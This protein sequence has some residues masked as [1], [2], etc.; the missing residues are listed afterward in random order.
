MSPSLLQLQSVGVQDLYLTA[1][2]EI[3]VFK[4]SYY[5]YVNFATETVRLPI[6]QT[7]GFGKNAVCDISR[8]GHLLSKLHLHLR[9]PK[10]TSPEPGKFVCWSDTLGYAIFDGEIELEIGGV[11]VDRMYPRF[12]EMYSELTNNDKTLG[13]NE[14]LLKSDVFTATYQNAREEVD[15]MIPLDFWF[16]RKYNMALPLLSMEGQSIRIR[17]TLRNFEDVVHYDT[18]SA[19]QEVSIID[20]G[21]F[22]EYIYLDEPILQEFADHKHVFL[23]EQVQYNQ[24]EII[25]ENTEYY[26]TKLLFNHPVKEVLFGCVNHSNIE[27]NNYYAY[28]KLRE[29]GLQLDGKDRFERLPEF[30]YRCILPDN[31]H[32][33][34]PMKYIYTMPFCLRPEDNQPTGALNM[35]RFNDIVLNLRLNSIPNKQ[36]LFVYGLSYNIL[37]IHNGAFAIEFSS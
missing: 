14:M 31:V 2:P 32:S 37:T 7:I 36:H 6:N 24:N 13:R 26:N 35:S 17:F 29:A 33:A 21:I 19:P 23:I 18:T 28:T 1:N 11:I 30:Y 16:T 9:L 27:T 34:I 3:N 15:L 20:A 25:P 22:A 12:S 8:R 4:Y 10:L 5:R